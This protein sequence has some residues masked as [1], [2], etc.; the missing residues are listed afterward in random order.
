VEG[1]R[2]GAR[3][4]FQYATRLRGRRGGNRRERMDAEEI[5]A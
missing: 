4:I 1:R 3:R 5:K 2:I